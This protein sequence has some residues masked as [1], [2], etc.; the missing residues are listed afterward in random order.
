MNFRPS[1][2]ASLKV[3]LDGFW[4]ACCKCTVIPELLSSLNSTTQFQRCQLQR[5]SGGHLFERRVLNDLAGIE[6]ER[7]FPIRRLT[8]SNKMTWSY[9]GPIRHFTFDES[10]VI[11]EIPPM[12]FRG[13]SHCI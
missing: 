11:E 9:R 5:R 6:A 4:I 13:K 3:S 2:D 1:H 10:T 8:D 7:K 12:S